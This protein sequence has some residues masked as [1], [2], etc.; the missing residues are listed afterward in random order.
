LGRDTGHRQALYRNLT[1][2][3]FAHE[4]IHTTHAKAKSVRPEAEKLITLAKRGLT[5]NQVHARRLAMSRINDSKIVKKL[6]DDLAPRYETR[7]GG[8]IRITKLGRRKGD[9]AE[10]VQMELVEE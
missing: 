4:V 5:G 9:G 2:Q 3:L 1:K 8:Y 7:P 10:M 6:F